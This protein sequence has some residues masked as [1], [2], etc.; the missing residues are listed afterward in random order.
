[1]LSRYIKISIILFFLSASFAFAQQ[2]KNIKP[3]VKKNQLTRILFIFDA[4]YS[5]NGM[6]QS[7]TKIAIAKKLLGELLD[8]LKQIENY[9]NIEVALR[10]Y[11]H[12]KPV[13]PQDCDD[14]R[15]EISFSKKNYDRIKNKLKT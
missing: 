12:Q 9:E 8:S 6:W 13:P 3:P 11:G 7:D 1:M 15:L 4:S 5:M 2:G 10:V 14:T